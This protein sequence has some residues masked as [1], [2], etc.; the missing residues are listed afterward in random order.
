VNYP[1]PPELDQP[2]PLFPLSTVLYPDGLLP[3]RIFE[4]RYLDMVSEALRNNSFFGIVPIR[5]G[6]ET[7]ET[8]DF[9]DVGTIANIASWDQGSDGL[10]QIQVLG[11]KSFRITSNGVRDNQ[12]LV[13]NIVFIDEA[14]DSA[15]PSQYAYL[16]E[17]LENAFQN[18]VG[19]PP[20]ESH[21]MDSASW[22]AHRLA[23]KLP[24]PLA[25][26]V[27]VLI[28]SGGHHKLSLLDKFLLELKRNEK[29]ISEKK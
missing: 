18:N 10:L 24:L 3:L 25:H 27:D 29:K 17:L 13:G 1:F 20:A 7:G 23:E 11:G 6:R 16:R 15:I 8:P 12:L 5:S 21:R 22:V 28:S 4:P 19:R 14:S 26:K 9:F 2:I